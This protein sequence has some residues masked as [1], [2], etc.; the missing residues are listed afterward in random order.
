MH[1]LNT[2]SHNFITKCAQKISSQN[3]LRMCT[4]SHDTSDAT[5]WW[6]QQSNDSVFSIQLTTEHYYMPG[7]DIILLRFCWKMQL[8]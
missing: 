6:L 5:D 3:V 7:K 1:L 8:Q 2:L 4:V